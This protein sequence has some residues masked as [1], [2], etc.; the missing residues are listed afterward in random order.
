MARPASPSRAGSQTR[1]QSH[2]HC[3][4]VWGWIPRAFPAAS[5][6]PLLD[7]LTLAG[8]TTASTELNQC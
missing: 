3:S 2:A 1:V 6:Q 7:W 4:R 5:S 8:M